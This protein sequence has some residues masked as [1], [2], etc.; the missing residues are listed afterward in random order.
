MAQNGVRERARERGSV[1]G[2]VRGSA[3][4]QYSNVNGSVM[5]V[6][7]S[8]SEILYASRSRRGQISVQ[9]QHEVVRLK[10]GVRAAM[11]LFPCTAS[12]AGPR[13]ASFG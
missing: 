4:L 7:I 5:E 3:F 11:D 10:L 8:C 9:D 6:M 2:S 1:N 13:K 12:F